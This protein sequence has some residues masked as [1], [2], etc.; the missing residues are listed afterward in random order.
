MLT[1][2]IDRYYT[3]DVIARR[4][5]ST[6]GLS[7]LH[8]VIDSACGDGRLLDAAQSA[9]PMACCV[10]IDR[11]GYAIRRLRRRR[12]NW[13]LIAGDA[14]DN[15]TWCAD[16]SSFPVQK[17]DVA[18]L[19]PPFSMGAKKGQ[20]IQVWGSNFRCSLAMAHILTTLEQTF[21]EEAVA[22]VPESLGYSELDSIGRSFLRK[23]YGFQI[24]EGLKNSTFRGARANALLIKLSRFPKEPDAIKKSTGFLI[25]PSQIIRGGLPVFEA[26]IAKQRSGI[27]Y[28]HTTNL[29]SVTRKGSLAM[30]SRVSP[31][32]RG[33]V[34]GV[35]V[36]LPRVGLPRREYVIP[37][38]F[39][40]AV[41]LS[42]CL[43]A[44]RF[45]SLSVAESFAKSLHS[46]WNDLISL[47]RGTGARYVTV[48]RLTA[49]LCSA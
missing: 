32:Q 19:N 40:E 41:Q 4:V 48:S 20:N 30:C 17:F 36:L 27:S 16:S 15:R 8:S 47:Y 7:R 2:D 11:D 28:I 49:W 9:H 34:S 31:I 13:V 24:I 3:P 45:Q 43:F 5:I 6:I 46:R 14:L 33:V 21:V 26:Q 29:L 12:P 23:L 18:V 35:V 10:G 42:D 1:S 38:R 44:I 22:I 39:S 37:L 25:C